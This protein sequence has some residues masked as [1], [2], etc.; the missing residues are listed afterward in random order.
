MSSRRRITLEEAKAQAAHWDAQWEQSAYEAA[1]ADRFKHATASEV[2]G[3]WESGDNEKGQPLTDFEFA[4]LCECWIEMFGTL[5]PEDDAS[6]TD[7]PTQH[8]LEPLAPDTLVDIK[9]VRRR[10]GISESTIKRMV[11]DG[12]FPKPMR[13]SPRRVAWPGRDIDALVKQL[14]QQRRAPRQ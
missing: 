12:R 8:A 2:V 5:P 4:A 1:L 11:L 9:E 13:P 6:A 14:D 10:T 3:M 7:L